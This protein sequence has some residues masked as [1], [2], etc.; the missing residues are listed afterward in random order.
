MADIERYTK[1][2]RNAD[3][4]LN[5]GLNAARG[6][7]QIKWPT[8]SQNYWGVDSSSNIPGDFRSTTALNN[9]Y[10]TNETDMVPWIM[11]DD[12]NKHRSVFSLKG[13]AR[14]EVLLYFSIPNYNYIIQQV[15]NVVNKN[16]SNP[17]GT[18]LTQRQEAT[19]RAEMLKVFQMK[20]PRSDPTDER[21]FIDTPEAT[22]SF[23]DELN[24]ILIKQAAYLIKMDIVS[25]S[26][27]DTHK[28]G[29]HFQTD[30]EVNS[31]TRNVG[32]FTDFTYY[33]L[34]TAAKERLPPVE[35]MKA[36]T[37][38]KFNTRYMS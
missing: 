22:R 23:I 32:Q 1:Y 35:S 27:A 28:T 9:G 31:T 34:G 24:A 19:A 3:N 13:H 26:A 8:Y 11:L 7:D 29:L 33:Y 38:A 12:F 37:N 10:G 30:V 6:Q 5:Y 16:Y 25:Q 18:K 15:T 36:I 4:I 21:T 20:T 17:V 2:N 14:Q